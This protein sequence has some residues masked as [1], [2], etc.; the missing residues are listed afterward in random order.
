VLHLGNQIADEQNYTQANDKSADLYSENNGL[1]TRYTSCLQHTNF[2]FSI[3]VCT[4]SKQLKEG[5]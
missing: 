4:T 1:V 2:L 5:L 3:E